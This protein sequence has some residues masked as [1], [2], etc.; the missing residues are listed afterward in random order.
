M[1]RCVSFPGNVLLQKRL[2]Y[3][4]PLL[5]SVSTMSKRDHLKGKVSNCTWHFPSVLL[6]FLFNLTPMH[7]HAVSLLIG[8]LWK[9]PLFPCLAADSISFPPYQPQP[10][11]PCPS[12]TWHPPRSSGDQHWGN[13]DVGSGRCEKSCC[14]T[15]RTLQAPPASKEL[16]NLYFVSANFSKT[17]AAAALSE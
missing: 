5:S 7:F 8:E 17:L 13:K 14:F 11:R 6:P 12:C 9:T 15:L 1:T 10:G 3:Y 4:I 2:H 16:L